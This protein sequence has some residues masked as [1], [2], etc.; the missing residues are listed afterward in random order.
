MSP[1]ILFQVQLT[2]YPIYTVGASVQ[3]QHHQLLI[4]VQY[5]SS[6]LVTPT[7][8]SESL[9]PWFPHFQRKMLY[10]IAF[11]MR[12]PK[13]IWQLKTIISRPG[14]QPSACTSWLW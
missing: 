1:T 8:L 9:N 10:S 11:L 13:K 5:W 4:V 6:A 7:E 2:K 3:V 12:E 14:C